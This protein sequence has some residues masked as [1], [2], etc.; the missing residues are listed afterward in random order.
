MRKDVLLTRQQERE[1]ASLAE[2][3]SERDLDTF[4]FTGEIDD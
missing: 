2:E 3:R 1:A 4:G